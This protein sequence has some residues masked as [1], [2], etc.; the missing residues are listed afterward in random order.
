MLSL[1]RCRQILGSKAADSDDA[2]KQV[3]ES[4]YSLAHIAVDVYAKPPQ[5]Y[6]SQ[7]SKRLSD[8]CHQTPATTSKNW[9]QSGN[10]T[11]ALTE[12]LPSGTLLA[13]I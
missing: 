9:P 7:I 4:L 10:T 12:T 1:H 11:A 13:I 6:L 2:I 3:R 5:T 8:R